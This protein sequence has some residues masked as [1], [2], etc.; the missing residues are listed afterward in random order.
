MP[1]RMALKLLAFLAPLLLP[2]LAEA[3]VMPTATQSFTNFWGASNSPSDPAADFQALGM[4]NYRAPC[5]SFP[6]SILNAGGGGVCFVDYQ[7]DSINSVITAVRNMLSAHPGSIIGV[8]AP[9]EP[10]INGFTTTDGYSCS[11]G[12]TPD[13]G[14]YTFAKA[15]YP[16]VKSDPVIGTNG[17]NLPVY[18]FTAQGAKDG[19]NSPISCWAGP[20]G[21]DCAGTVRTADI[22]SL[23]LYSPGGYEADQGLNP[24]SSNH[25]GEWND[26]MLPLWGSS[27]PG[28]SLSSVQQLKWSVT[29][30]GCNLSSG[31]Q[32]S[33]D[34]H[35]GTATDVQNTQYITLLTAAYEHHIGKVSPY[36]DAIMI[37][38][39]QDNAGS[40]GYFDG[41]NVARSAG[42]T[43]EN[44]KTILADTGTTTLAPANVTLSGLLSTGHW[45][46]T[47]KHDGSYWLVAWTEGASD[48]V[49][50]NFGAASSIA[51]KVF[52]PE[53]GTTAVQTGSV[54]DT[55]ITYTLSGHPVVINFKVT[56]GS[57]ETLAATTPGTQTAGTQ[58]TVSGTYTNGPPTALDYST[59][60]LNGAWAATAGSTIGSG[61]WSFPLTITTANPSQTV[62]VRDHANINI[63]ACTNPFAVNP[64]GGGG[65]TH[66]L[67]L[68]LS[69]YCGGTG[70]CITANWNVDGTTVTF[71]PAF[72]RTIGSAVPPNNEAAEP[73]GCSQTGTAFT[74]TGSWTTGSHTLNMIL[75]TGATV[76]ADICV[77]KVTVDGTVG[78]NPN[79]GQ[80]GSPRLNRFQQDGTYA[81]AFSVAAA[82][83]ETLTT[84]VPPYHGVPITVTGVIQNMSSAPASLDMKVDGGTAT[85]ASCS[86][87][88]ASA[89]TC[90]WTP[91]TSGSH[92]VQFIDHTTSVASNVATVVI[93]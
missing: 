25:S 83:T 67:V 80:A 47:Q 36:F 35:G 64:A 31:G 32:D 72:N 20:I 22:G 60:G 63:T 55:S 73:A 6:A 70:P 2:A 45:F 24:A 84:N 12:N 85:S 52:D 81:I 10:S 92:T 62:C 13:P 82:A 5:T 75:P 93:N 77:D 28:Y 57:V 50:F 46:L 27:G 42:T 3:Q 38:Q 68:N 87:L 18:S 91:S 44:Y 74:T 79:T 26:M 23:H 41:S 1:K 30:A 17:L 37:Y 66:T 16:A 56:G 4:H 58:F 51:P 7:G 78:T 8:E 43:Q 76:A 11:S 53:S 9:N 86:V 39:I 15:F 29:E 61:A 88:T 21:N 65:G 19:P 89:F 59:T 54:N 34:S 48:T 33:C 14:C 71:T 69:Q 49:T 40:Y 90:S